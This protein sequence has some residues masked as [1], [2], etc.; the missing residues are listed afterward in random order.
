MLDLI[1]SQLTDP[2]RIGLLIALFVTMLRT[3]AA[4]GIVLPLA[5]GIVFVAVIVPTTMGSG[6]VLQTGLAGVVSNAVIVA[7]IYGIWT[8]YQRAKSK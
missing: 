4:S 7:A 8:I 3:R 2:F 6:F 1:N 5:A